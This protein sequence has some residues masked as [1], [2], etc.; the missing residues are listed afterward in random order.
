MVRLVCGQSRQMTVSFSPGNIGANNL[1]AFGNFVFW[2]I[3]IAPITTSLPVM[4]LRTCST[5]RSTKP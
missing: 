3:T 5:P 1:T 2:S 4:I